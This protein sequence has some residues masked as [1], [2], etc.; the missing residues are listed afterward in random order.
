MPYPYRQYDPAALPCAYLAAVN[1]N[2]DV[3]ESVVQ[4]FSVPEISLRGRGSGQNTS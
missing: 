1:D 4:M 3:K 2:L